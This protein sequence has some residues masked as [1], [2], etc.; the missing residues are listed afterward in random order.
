MD[1]GH[2]YFMILFSVVYAYIYIEHV[3]WHKKLLK[4]HMRVVRFNVAHV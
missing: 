3:L 2:I 1:A 4:F